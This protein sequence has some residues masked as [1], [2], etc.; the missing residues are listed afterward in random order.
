MEKI[1]NIQDLLK[2]FEDKHSNHFVF[3]GE[4]KKFPRISS[5]GFRYKSKEQLEDK[6]DFGKLA[7]LNNYIDE[8]YRQI[9]YKLDD[10]ERDN[11]LTYAQHHGIPTNLI[12]VSSSVSA[13]LYFATSEKDLEKEK[14][15]LYGF[16]TTKMIKLLPENLNRKNIQS[17]YDILIYEDY[18]QHSALVSNIYYEL[19]RIL[20][21]YEYE[22][23][24]ERVLEATKNIFK[25]LVTLKN[26]FNS[27]R[28]KLQNIFKVILQR[29][30]KVN[31]NEQSDYFSWFNRIVIKNFTENKENEV[32]NSLLRDY[33]HLKKALRL[34]M[35]YVLD[36]LTLWIFI[37]LKFAIYQFNIGAVD[38]LV[39]APHML[40]YPDMLFD[41][42]HS[43][44]GSFIYQNYFETVSM[45][46]ESAE[47]IHPDIV[48]EVENKFTILAQLDLLGVNQRELFPDA[49]NIASYIKDKM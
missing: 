7:T 49:D 47:V 34:E 26:N 6:N 30:N 27:D 32:I 17:I 9:G 10:I 11:F 3:R 19:K 25:V 4:S 40:Y 20:T 2:L 15:Y 44:K 13:A 24:N 31:T 28:K 45:Q 35:D 8:Y 29:L 42:M 23:T 37:L 48:I 41:R 12:D 1:S 14:G 18:D 21:Y 38:V 22:D 43:Q 39:K 33:H 16:D 46:K 36:I 5:S